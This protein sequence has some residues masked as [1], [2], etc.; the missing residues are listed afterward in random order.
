M[1]KLKGVVRKGSRVMFNYTDRNGVTSR[2]VIEV[3]S[4]EDRNGKILYR[5]TDLMKRA[6]RQFYKDRMKDPV[7]SNY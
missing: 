6:P 7:V 5:G 3:E 1:K 4:V 2:R